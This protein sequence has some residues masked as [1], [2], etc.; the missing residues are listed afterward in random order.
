M[1]LLSAAVRDASLYGI[2]KRLDRKRRLLSMIPRR[3][4]GFDNSYI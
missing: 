3:E 1:S 2:Y 4:S